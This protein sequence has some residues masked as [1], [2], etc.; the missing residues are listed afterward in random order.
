VF[1]LHI[2]RSAQGIK[3]E[4]EENVPISE[5][6]SRLVASMESMAARYLIIWFG[7]MRRLIA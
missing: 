1:H 5:L 7:K 6:T 3:D 4:A 2:L